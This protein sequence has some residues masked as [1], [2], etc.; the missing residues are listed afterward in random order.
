MCQE[1]WP[2]V[3]RMFYAL[4]DVES[5][6]YQESLYT[7]NRAGEHF[8]VPDPPSA[9]PAERH[10]DLAMYKNKPEVARACPTHTMDFHVHDS[11]KLYLHVYKGELVSTGDAAESA[12]LASVP[13]SLKG[14]CF[15]QVR[16]D[17]SRAARRRV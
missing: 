17:S 6:P 9:D 1:R 16:C 2:V 10:V 11:L 12:P 5:A 15:M 14:S 7:V 8:V 13:W 4:I 3:N